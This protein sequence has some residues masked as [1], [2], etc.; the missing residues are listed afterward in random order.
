[1]SNTQYYVEKARRW[2]ERSRATVL[3][4][5]V[6]YLA[7]H[8]CFDCGESDP[9]VLEFDHVRRQGKV[10]ASAA[11]IRRDASWRVIEAEI[12]KCVV[13]CANCHRRRTA[14]Q[15]GWGKLKR[16]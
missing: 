8:P 16:P 10:A 6:D 2:K 14:L 9:I 13:R 4:K 5:L 12:A 1:V 7:T 15:F 11:L 3:D